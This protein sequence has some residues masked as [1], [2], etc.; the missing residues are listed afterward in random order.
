MNKIKEHSGLINEFKEFI[1]RGSVMDLYR[2]HHHRQAHYSNCQF[3]GKRHQYAC[4]RLL[5]EKSISKICR[6]L[7]NQL[8]A[9]VNPPYIGTFIQNIVYFLIIAF[10]GLLMVKGLNA[11]NGKSYPHRR[12]PNRLFR[13]CKLLPEIIDLLKINC[14]PFLNT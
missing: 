8:M 14:D 12:Q 7:I 4:K 11:S 10:V 9:P 5:N 2:R 6:L 3:S 1:S 13:R